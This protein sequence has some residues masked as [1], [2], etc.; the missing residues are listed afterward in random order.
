[1]VHWQQ[2]FYNPV[3]VSATMLWRTMAMEMRTEMTIE[4]NTETTTTM[5]IP[6]KD[7]MVRSSVQS[8]RLSLAEKDR[9][10]TEMELRL[11]FP[12]YL[13]YKYPIKDVPQTA[14]CKIWRFGLVSLS[15]ETKISSINMRIYYIVDIYNEIPIIAC[16]YFSL[17][18][19]GWSPK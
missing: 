18:L 13:L 12:I 19:S 2:L 6:D 14:V 16:T 17:I 9:G 10:T 11:R 4:R 3:L 5:L 15:H 1:M 8:W 7:N